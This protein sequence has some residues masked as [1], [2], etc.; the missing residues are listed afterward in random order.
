MWPIYTIE[1]HIIGGLWI[2]VQDMPPK[3][4]GPYPLLG[5]YSAL[6]NNGPLMFRLT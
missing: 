3:R 6:Q 5:H 2:E 1:L 4:A